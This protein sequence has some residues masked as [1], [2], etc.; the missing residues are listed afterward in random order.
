MATVRRI[1]RPAVADYALQELIDDALSIADALG[2]QRFHLVGHDWGAA[3]GWALLARAPERI[4][5][6]HALSIPHLAA[7][8][9]SRQHDAE[10]RRRSRYMGL[11]GMPWLPEQLFAFDGL[12]LLAT[13]LYGAH[14]VHHRQ[15]YLALFAEPGALT[16]ALNWYRAT[17]PTDWSTVDDLISSDVPVRF[18]WGKRDPAVSAQAVARARKLMPSNYRELELDAGHWL[19]QEQGD[20]IAERV[21]RLGDDG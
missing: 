19:M 18:F 16:A 3:V 12:D 13:T 15:E 10:Q 1:A 5:S 20:L 14:P 6:W 8:A 17:T 2:A 4:L 11:F 7:F 21:L 9:Q